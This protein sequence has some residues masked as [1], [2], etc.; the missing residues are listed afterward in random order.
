MNLV[1][2]KEAGL[3]ALETNSL[4]VPVP[5]RPDSGSANFL[6]SILSTFFGW[7]NSAVRRGTEAP[8]F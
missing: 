5:C 2:V 6:H 1:P 7:P 3:A 8:M 4:F